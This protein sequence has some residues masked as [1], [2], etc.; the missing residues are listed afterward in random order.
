MAAISDDQLV[1]LKATLVRDFVPHLP[2]LL[3]PS[4]VAV[5]NDEKNVARALAGFAVAK[6]CGIE[7][8]E[9]AQAVVDDG[10]DYGIDAI[11]YHAATETLYIVQSKLK[12]TS[13]VQ[14]DA[15]AFCQGL[16]KLISQNFS[17][18]N[19]NILKR[20]VELE[21]AVSDCSHIVPVVIHTGPG[22]VTH[23]E[24]AL[25]DCLSEERDEDDRIALAITNFD[26]DRIVACLRESHAYNRVDAKVIIKPWRYHDQPRQT[27]FGFIALADLVKLFKRDGLALFA[28]NLRNPLGAPNG[29]RK[30]HT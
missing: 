24:K 7:P 3:T 2:P 21:D 12:A 22:L 27:Y 8:I 9:A 19:D 26:S 28:K 23:A 20:Q 18:F 6:L 4:T 15:L 14:D 5:K 30:S 29:C 11:Y 16:K 17:N 1:V 13:F 10:N 25:S